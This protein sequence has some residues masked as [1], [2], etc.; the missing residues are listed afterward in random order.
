MVHR[1]NKMYI[2][3][4][5][6]SNQTQARLLMPGALTDIERTSEIQPLPLHVWETSGA[7]KLIAL[8]TALWQYPQNVLVAYQVMKTLMPSF[9]FDY[10]FFVFHFK[11]SHTI[12]LTSIYPYSMESRKY[13]DIFLNSMPS[14]PIQHTAVRRSNGKT[15]IAW[16]LEFFQKI[17]SN[18]IFIFY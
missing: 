1:R 12:I 7:W 2:K 6:S 17:N 4:R 13:Q 15:T 9:T 8:L 18:D 5:K 14:V 11:A 3:V 16:G 10:L